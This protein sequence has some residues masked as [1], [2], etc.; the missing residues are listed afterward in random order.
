MV[1][2]D[3]YKGTAVEA[4]ILP[5]KFSCELCRFMR[6][7]KCING[8]V[9][10]DPLLDARRII[11]FFLSFYEITGKVPHQDLFISE[12]KPGV[13]K[14]IHASKVRQRCNRTSMEHS[15]IQYPAGRARTEVTTH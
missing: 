12:G 14:I 6:V 5:E 1:V 3:V 13:G 9:K 10:S 8:P 4:I 2:D 15:L 7:G 11:E